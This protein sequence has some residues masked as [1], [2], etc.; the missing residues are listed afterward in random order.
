LRRSPFRS[1]ENSLNSS[2]YKD[3]DGL[4]GRYPKIYKPSLQA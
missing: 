2:R 3:I 1:F 4:F